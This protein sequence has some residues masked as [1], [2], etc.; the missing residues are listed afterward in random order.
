MSTYVCVWVCVEWGRDKNP[1][2]LQQH[3]GSTAACGLRW[4]VQAATPAQAAT[5]SQSCALGLQTS[6]SHAV[7]LASL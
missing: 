6:C 3:A 4:C 2:G 5:L 7:L 1:E